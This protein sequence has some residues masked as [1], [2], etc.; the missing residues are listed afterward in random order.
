MKDIVRR[1][2][3]RFMVGFE[4]FAASADVKALIRDFGVGHVVL[5]ARNVAGPEQVA[6]LVRERESVAREAGQGRR[7]LVRM[8]QEGGRETQGP[9]S[10]QQATRASN[11]AEFRAL[12]RSW[13]S[14]AVKGLEELKAHSPVP[15]DLEPKQKL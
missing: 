4:G 15:Q 6:D 2:G 11:T 7:V 13:A 1:V 3:Q 9:P 12:F 5:F 10:M 14:T 8:G